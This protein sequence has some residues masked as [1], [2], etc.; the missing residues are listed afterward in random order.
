M[1]SMSPWWGGQYYPRSSAGPSELLTQNNK[2][3][4][5]AVSVLLELFVGR[6]MLRK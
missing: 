5:T 6:R 4:N 3:I 2:L 1:S